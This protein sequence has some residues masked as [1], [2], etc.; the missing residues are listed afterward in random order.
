[1][2]TSDF[3]K[4]IGS[5]LKTVI[6]YHKVAYCPSRGDLQPNTALYWPAQP[7][8]M[9]TIKCCKYLGLDLKPHLESGS[10]LISFSP[11]ISREISFTFFK[12]FTCGVTVMYLA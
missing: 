3:A 1:M 8:R 10:M 9:R 7:T 12:T 6:Y 11:D 4:L 2:T 5:T